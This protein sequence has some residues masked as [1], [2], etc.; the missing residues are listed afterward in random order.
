MSAEVRGPRLD[1]ALD[2]VTVLRLVALVL[3]ASGRLPAM[4]TPTPKAEVA[5]EAQP[6]AAD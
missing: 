4:A 6:L 5:T 1:R 2:G 3:E